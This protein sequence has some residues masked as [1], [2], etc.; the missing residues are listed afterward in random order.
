[1]TAV[2]RGTLERGIRFPDA[3]VTGGCQLQ[4]LGVGSELG[5]S[6][7]TAYALSH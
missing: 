3:A 5:S 4:D 2:A 7:R 6:A 1:M